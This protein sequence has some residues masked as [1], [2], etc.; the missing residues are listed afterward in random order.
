MTIEK[1]SSIDNQ[2]WIGVQYKIFGKLGQEE[3]ADKILD[4]WGRSLF[5]SGC[6]Q[7]KAGAEFQS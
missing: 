2:M 1:K 5:D 4:E 7:N 6:R 3:L